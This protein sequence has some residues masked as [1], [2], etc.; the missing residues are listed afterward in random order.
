MNRNFREK[1][2]LFSA[3]TLLSC[4]AVKAQQP[5]WENGIACIIY[6]RCSPC[7]NENGIAPFPLMSYDDAIANVFGIKKAVNSGEMP[8]YPA[9]RTYQHYQN[10]RYMSDEEKLAIN[11]WIKRG[12][13]SGN[14][15]NALE[16]P[17][18]DYK[19]VI[20]NPDFAAAIPTY[21][22]PVDITE[23]LYRCFVVSNP[24]PREQY[25]SAVEIIPGNTSAVHHVLV[26]QDTSR[27]PVDLDAADPLP[28]YSMFGGIGSLSAELVKG[29]S[30]GQS[31]NWVYPAGM[32]TRIKPNA[33]LII[34]VHYPPEAAGKIDSTRVNLLFTN[35]PR[36]REIKVEPLLN[37]R[38]TMINK[39]FRIPA[40]TVKTFYEA[41]TVPGNQGMS[42]LGITP[43]A[44]LVCVSMKSYAVTPSNDTVPLI[45]IPHWDFHWQGSYMF[46]ELITLPGGSTIY[47]EAV[48]DN[49]T[50][51]PHNPNNPPR[52]VKGGERT[53]DEMMMFYLFYTKTKAGDDNIVFDTTTRLPTY[54]DCDFVYKS[55]AAD[56]NT[57]TAADAANDT[58]LNDKSITVYPNPVHNQLNVS[59]NIA[60]S[61]KMY[62]FAAGGKMV[63]ETIARPGNNRVDVRHLQPGIYFIKVVNQ[64]I[65]STIRVIKE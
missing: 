9:D 42:L 20:T 54:N 31:S 46:K 62:V 3:L 23:D 32:G 12:A 10:E 4:I 26:F 5:T 65:N 36:V 43:H 41:Y 56:V 34:Q 58:R 47:G 52:L 25:I 1:L 64:S 33:R 19:Q 16:P 45:N 37:E 24:F 13:P 35:A 61:A 40:N 29:W 22:V 6:S 15:D 8:P 27:I 38:Y 57:I 17:V 14:L 55:S 2:Y 39:P 59:L 53:T 44:H 50:N 60:A 28:G 18:Y 11:Q 63:Y 49:T 48:Y 7:H 21:Q 30:P 51:N